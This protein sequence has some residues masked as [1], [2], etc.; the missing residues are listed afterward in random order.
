MQ[1]NF[2]NRVRPMTIF[3]HPQILS[4]CHLNVLKLSP[5]GE[6]FNPPKMGQ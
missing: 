4:C 5:K 1:M 3:L 6:G 2:E